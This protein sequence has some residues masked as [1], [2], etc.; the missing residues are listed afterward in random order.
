MLN[1][2]REGEWVFW[3]DADWWPTFEIDSVAYYRKITFK[4]GKPVGKAYAYYKSGQLEWE[5]YFLSF[6]LF[7]ASP[8]DGKAIWYYDNGN[9]SFEC[10]RINEI[11]Q[12]EAIDYYVSG[13]V[14]SRQ[15][16]VDGYL[17]GEI[18]WYYESGITKTTGQYNM[19]EKSGKWRYYFEDGSFDSED[20]YTLMRQEAKWNAM[21]LELEELE[22]QE[23]NDEAIVKAG[24][25][26]QFTR[27]SLGI[28]HIKYIGSLNRL[29]LAYQK[30]GKYDTA[31]FFFTEALDV[32]G[33]LLGKENSNYGLCLG[34]L[35]L[36]NDYLGKYEKAEQYY[37]LALNNLE[38]S[39][40]E[41]HSYYGTN[42]NNLAELY[43]SM[44]QYEKALPLFLEALKI[45]EQTLGKDY[46]GYGVN[47]MNLAI[48]YYDMGLYE[49]ALPLYEEALSITEKTMGK[50]HS[51][52]G[53]CLSNMAL[54]YEEIGLYKKALP[55]YLEALANIEKALGKDHSEYGVRLNNLALVYKHM[56]EN[57]K[58][59]QM[60]I[61]ALNNT[62]KAF[63]KEHP[64]YAIRLNNIAVL[65]DHIGE[66]EKAL[67]LY[68]EVLS[69]TEKSL[70]KDHEKYG[71][72]L[73]NL[74]IYYG[75]HGQNEKALP[76][77][78]EALSNAEKSLGKEHPTYAARL[79]N[80]ASFYKNM[81]QHEKA[82][83][84]YQEAFSVIVK[85]LN[86]NFSFLSEK[87]KTV[88]SET[89]LYYFEIYKSFYLDHYREKP[90]LAADVF[91][92]ELAAKGLLLNSSIEM[93]QKISGSG[94]SVTKRTFD[95]W[96]T[97]KLVL[98][99]QYGLPVSERRNDL[100]ELEEK[101]NKLESELARL[102]SSF[103]QTSSSPDTKWVDI[104]NALKQNEVA[105]E[106]STFD[107]YNRKGWTDSTMYV[108]L[109]LRKS[110]NI[111]HLIPLC[112]GRQL[113]NLLKKEG[114]SDAGFI[115]NLYRGAVVEDDD[116]IATSYGKKIYD[117][118]WKPLDHLL[119]ESDKVYFS[120]SGLLHQMAFAA[121]PYNDSSLLSDYYE[122]EQLSNTAKLLEKTKFA[123]MI[124]SDIVLFGGIQYELTKADMP[125]KGKKQNTENKYTS[126]S[127]REGIDRGGNRWTYL[128]GT[129][130][131]VNGIEEIAKKR[132]VKVTLYT[133]KQGNEESFK[134]LSGKNAPRVLHIATHGF[135][136]AD[137]Q[138]VHH[139]ISST[140]SVKQVFR[141]SD[142][143]L[144]R[145]GLLFAGSNFAWGGGTLTADAEDGILTAYEATN[146]SLT[147]TQLV[148]L[149]ACETGLGEIKG[150]E[151]VFGLQ[152]AFKA[153][154]TEYLLMSL[155]KVPDKETAEFMAFFYNYWF[156]GNPIPTAYYQTQQYMKSKY[157][158]D[159]FKW[160]VFVLVR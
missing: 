16:Y 140:E 28:N 84:Y 7:T 59:L 89:V 67:P 103:N 23:K 95:E 39:L 112:E 56:G 14:K 83:P 57:E 134:D 90:S 86:K 6:N 53:I 131:E 109:V 87:E 143:P 152:R 40:G 157:P 123:D 45:K 34:S 82:L 46:W 85:N 119:K 9:K 43:R 71:T 70:G 44:G 118:I 18:I 47:L 12:G 147:N 81:G 58:A 101:A 33:K 76:L 74:A 55:M 37:L 29:G 99:K 8:I 151:G 126:R 97:L 3:Y 137:P 78:L 22:S 1:N 31:L 156:N 4:E 42:T 66:Y 154:G 15:T 72:N 114:S 144:N 68:L 35:A 115:T 75:S 17:N 128:P 113:E 104:Q 73:C 79:N 139:D 61:E 25:I 146:V 36:I 127:L 51:Q 27:D 48:L 50:D 117:M 132:K 136:F 64:S 41:N 121:I 155:W 148:V 2:E 93:R 80:L 130:T 129:L 54:L 24:E 62:E 30:N 49:K 69:I 32:S 100:E 159:P 160:A 21:I 65:Y 5:G 116:G 153:A 108:A 125:P 10:T 19:G 120:P 142:N 149:S 110:D 158:N 135:F 88:Y 60:A 133:G 94:D 96:N 91:D 106:F 122:L 98:G 52:Y 124:P 13:P 26:L 107:Y 150:S 38:K 92:I 141:S 105:I 145:A 111:P 77:Y 102:S 11:L 138:K 63:G 20:D